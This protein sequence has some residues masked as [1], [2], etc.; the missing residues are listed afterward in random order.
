LGSKSLCYFLHKPRINLTS[1]RIC[2]SLKASPHA[3]ITVDRPTLC[4]PPLMIFKST[5]S[6][7]LAIAWQLVK[8]AGFGSSPRALG[9]S[10]FPPTPWHTE[11]NSWKSTAGFSAAKTGLQKLQHRNP[12]TS[13]KIDDLSAILLLERLQRFR[14][15]FSVSL[16]TF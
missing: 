1:S 15:L 6:E 12:N 10:P 14:A 11:H 5:S 4:P 8:S 7:S 13:K 9:P 16:C 3:G 2:C